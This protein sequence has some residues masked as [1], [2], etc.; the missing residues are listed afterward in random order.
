MAPPAAFMRNLLCVL[1]A[2]REHRGGGSGI[3]WARAASRML[4]VVSAS[5][6]S[7]GLKRGS[8]DDQGTF[9]PL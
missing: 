2:I 5:E 6:H 7:L 4:A 1:V 9:P 3:V 8:R